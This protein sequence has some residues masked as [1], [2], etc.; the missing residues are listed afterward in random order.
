M[1]WASGWGL[2]KEREGPRLCQVVVVVVVVVVVRCAVA[3][4]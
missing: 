4:V 3:A 2:G 1:G